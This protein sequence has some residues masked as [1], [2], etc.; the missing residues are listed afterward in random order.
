MRGSLRPSTSRGFTSAVLAAGLGALLVTGGCGGTIDGG[1]APAGGSDGATGSADAAAAPAS[2]ADAGAGDPSPAPVPV[3]PALRFNVGMNG[4]ASEL[5]GLDAFRLASQMPAGVPRL[6]HIYTYWDIANHDPGTGNQTHKS[7]AGLVA[8]FGQA[9]GRCDRVLVTFKGL[10]LD[11]PTAPPSAA[12]FEQSFLDFVALTGDGQPLAG[13]GDKLDFTPWNE[14]NNPAPSGNGLRED[15]SPE[16]A[17]R[18]YLSIRKHCE[19]AAGCEVAAGDFATNGNTARDIAWNCA[20]DNDP[21]NTT[22]RCAHPSSMNPGDSA[23]SYLDRYKNFIAVHAGD[24]GL[25][26]GFRPE[27][28]A[29]HPWHDV[30]SYIDANAVCSS[31]QNCATR[32][33]L[34]SLG[35]SWGGVEIWDNEIGVG[36]QNATPPDENTTQPCGAAFLV[37]LTELSPRVT[38]LYYMHFLSGHGPLFDGG[39]TLRPAGQV[40][41]GRATSYDGASCAPTGLPVN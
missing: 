1:P 16:L 27:A 35:G 36:L 7:L 11:T 26:A 31:Y 2:D 18:Y 20:N 5:D 39:T 19:P 6:C 40:L 41:A 4:P 38:R 22:T 15:L 37:R 8:W 21:A 3:P 34:K 24:Y 14:P 9:Q 23:P 29:Y 13:W 12:A 28:F 25:P 30:N 10:A 17:A 33:L 32:R